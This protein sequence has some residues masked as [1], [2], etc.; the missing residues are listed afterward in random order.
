MI[1]SPEISFHLPGHPWQI[2]PGTRL[3]NMPLSGDIAHNRPQVGEQNSRS[4]KNTDQNYPGEFTVGDY[5]LAARSVLTQNRGRLLARAVEALCGSCGPINSLDICLVKHGAFYH[6][7]KIKV[8]TQVFPPVY[9]VLNGAV[10]DPGV[11]LIKTEY[12]FLNQLARQVVPCF[13][14]RVFGADTICCDKGETAFFLGQ[15]FEGFFEFHVTRTSRGTQVAVW[16]DDGTRVVISWEQAARIYEKIAY[17]LTLYYDICTGHEIH[18]WHHAAGD[19]VVASTEDSFAVRLITV[20]GFGPLTEMASA[21]SAQGVKQLTCML[22]Y[23]LNLTLRMRLDRL[24]GTGPV[25]FLPQTVLDATIKGML[26]ALN[27]RTTGCPEV[28][29]DGRQAP[30]DIKSAFVDFLTGFNQNQLMDIMTGL[31]DAWH[32]DAAELDLIR[33]NLFSHCCRIRSIFKI[34]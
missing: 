13:I 15:W 33:A 5:F 12:R 24:D 25:V 26:E 2:L 19:F 23:F 21:S 34:P 9:L 10:K 27:H 3:W 7:L 30:E 29:N 14:P 20:R 32:P 4:G 11:S 18:P 17:I 28:K 22:F 8:E 6:P 31:V 1:I 16:E